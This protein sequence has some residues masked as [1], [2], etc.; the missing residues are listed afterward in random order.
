MQIS[1]RG[2]M[3][4]LGLIE[5]LLGLVSTYYLEY[6][7]VIWGVGFGLMHI[8]YGVYMHQKYEK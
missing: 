2:S 1:T 7:L 6:A 3:R 5:I 8:A 4:S